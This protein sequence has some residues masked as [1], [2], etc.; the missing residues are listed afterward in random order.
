MDADVGGPGALP[1][2]LQG[3]AAYDAIVLSDVA[4]THFSGA[5]LDTLAAWVRDL[6]GGLVMLGGSDSFGAG[7]YWHTPVEEILPVSM[8]VKDRSYLPSVGL[9]L[10]IDKSGSMAGY[11]GVL[12]IEVG[13]AAAMAVAEILEPVGATAYTSRLLEAKRRLSRRD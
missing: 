1:A 8:E 11:E 13:K 2:D 4:A 6:G 3:L 7:G 5:Q 10:L 12:K 9:V